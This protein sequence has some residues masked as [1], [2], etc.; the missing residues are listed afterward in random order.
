MAGGTTTVA[1]MALAYTDSP[2]TDLKFADNFT[3]GTQ[4]FFNPVY[5]V[6]PKRTK[7][8]NEGKTLRGRNFQHILYKVKTHEPVISSN[9]LNVNGNKS[10]LQAFWEAYYQYISVFDG[11]N[12]SDYI[13]VDTPG[14][15]FPIEYI[16][17]VELF[18]EVK[19][20]LIEVVP[21]V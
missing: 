9:E 18:P 12:W 15:D 4:R 8:V 19:L 1:V 21:Y 17:S 11:T 14:G 10:F 2:L 20:I 6:P 13:E 16:E 3:A 7:M 5:Y